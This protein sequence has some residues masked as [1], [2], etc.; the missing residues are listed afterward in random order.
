MSR[1]NS[2]VA[3]KLTEE[4][5]KYLEKIKRS[6]KEEIRKVRRAEIILLSASGYS[7][8]KIK[9]MLKIHRATVKNCLDK[10][11]TIGVESALKDL[12][13]EGA[14][15]EI[16]DEDRTLIINEACKS[17]LELDYPYTLWTYSLLTEHIKKQAAIEGKA[18]LT[19]IAKSTIWRIL[20]AAEIKPHRIKYY[21]E[22]RDEEFEKKMMDLL[23]IYKEIE[24][25]NEKLRKGEEKQIDKITI[26]Y[27][28]K[29]G[30]Q[31]IGNVA[32]DLMPVA[33]RH[34]TVSRDAE[35]KRYGTISLL[36]GMNLHTGKVTHHI[37]AT[38]KSSDFIDFLEKVDKEYSDIEKIR[39]ILDNHSAHVS[40]ETQAYLSEKANRFDFVF[41]PKHGSWLNLIESFFSKMAKTVLR[42]IRVNSI[43]DL[44]TRIEKYFSMVNK[45]P[46]I[47]RWKYKMDTI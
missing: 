17:P 13:R 2:R 19:K 20:N 25:T 7:D 14:P 8:Y 9:K 18:R 36:A 4:E 47:Y 33:H 22:K 11:V 3:V 23:F 39:I 42:E 34:K 35:Y 15:Q 40:K 28:E 31:A 10:C 38:H 24:L 37:S 27:D 44:I 45:N 43:D 12:P 26:S 32:K 21:L 41:T 6:S 1:L 29:P 30:I 16:P 5:K 46:V